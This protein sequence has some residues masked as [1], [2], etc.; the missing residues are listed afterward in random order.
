MREAKATSAQ[1]SSRLR[2]VSCSPLPPLAYLGVAWGALQRLVFLG[3]QVLHVMSSPSLLA[4]LGCLSPGAPSRLPTPR[5]RKPVPTCW[6]TL[7]ETPLLRPRQHHHLLHSQPLGVR[8]GIRTLIQR[9]YPLTQRIHFPGGPGFT[10][11]SLSS[12]EQK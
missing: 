8:L 4:N 1:E 6:L 5:S 10:W 2:A 11:P 9:M 7:V 3:F 12:H